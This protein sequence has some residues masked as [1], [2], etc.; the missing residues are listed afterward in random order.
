MSPRCHHQCGE[1][2]ATSRTVLDLDSPQSWPEELLAYLDKHHDLF[3]HWETQQGNPSPPV[4][5]AALRGLGDVVQLYEILGWHCTR[6]TDSEAGEILCKGMKLPNAVMLAHRVDI[7]LNIG[8][9]TPNIAWRLKSENQADV[10]YRAGMVWFCFFPPQNAGESGIERFFRH[11]GGEALY[12][13]HEDDPVTSSAISTI[14]KPRLVEADVPIAL[15]HSP[16]S[17]ALSIYRRYL[18]SRGT[19]VSPPS[20]YEDRIVHPLPAENVRRIVTFPEPDFCSLTG[21]C[22][23][24][25]PIRD[26]PSDT[27]CA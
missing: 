19:S 5:D 3:L 1:I 9:I 14:G 10:E 18:I 21:C 7:L 8:C 6:L 20:D 4:F 17:L 16:V 13:C 24:R 2:N 27:N 23:W 22:D 12:V 15:L 26:N 25:N 11:W